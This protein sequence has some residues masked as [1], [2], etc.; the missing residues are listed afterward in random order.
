MN[1]GKKQL[2]KGCFFVFV[3]KKIMLFLFIYT[4][5]SGIVDFFTIY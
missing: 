5:F 4:E 2:E 1:W 3:N